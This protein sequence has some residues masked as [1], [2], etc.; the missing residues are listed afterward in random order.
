[1]LDQLINHV[2]MHL[3]N[4]KSFVVFVKPQ[5][6]HLEGWFSSE[7]ADEA[8]AIGPQNPAQGPQ[9]IMQDFDVSVPAKILNK[10]DCAV[11]HAP[12]EEEPNVLQDYNFTASNETGATY[13]SLI[14][15]AIQSMRNGL[16]DK[17]VL[18]RA[19]QIDLSH[20][21]WSLLLSRLMSCDLKAF[22]YLWHHPDQGIW[23]GA[24]PE[25]LI[26]GGDRRYQT[27]ALAGTQWNTRG[28]DVRWTTKE[29]NEHQWVIDD[30]HQRLDRISNQVEI[31][32]TQTH[33]A[34]RLQHLKTGVTGSLQH[35]ISFLEAAL[36]L[37]PTPAVCGYPRSQAQAFIIENEGYDRCYYTG[38]LGLIDNAK[39]TAAL[40]VN[41]RCM[42]VSGL[43]ARIYVGG[44]LTINSDP[45]VEFEETQKKL[46]T[47][48]SV[49]APFLKSGL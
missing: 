4:Q 29:R 30:I 9:F 25:L 6:V 33:Q 1:M 45:E 13:T 35:G 19:H 41:L 23:L 11:I 12:L 24:T 14:V 32:P 3:Q 34:G 47:M 44:G 49:I 43:N 18:S 28:E 40:F 38:F 48:G 42:S 10:N 21:D 17:V 36:V 37:H 46:G 27:M 2:R 20:C 5:E 8:N 31:G 26:G 15:K 16:F 39:D 7:Q 22:R